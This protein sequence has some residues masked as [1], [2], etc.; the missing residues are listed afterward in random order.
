MSVVQM[1]AEGGDRTRTP[2]HWQNA[3]TTMAA[4]GDN[5]V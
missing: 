5:C 3:D 4:R 2:E 1:S